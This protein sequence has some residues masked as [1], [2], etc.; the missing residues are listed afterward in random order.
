MVWG[1]VCLSFM[2]QL[3]DRNVLQAFTFFIWPQ[4]ARNGVFRCRCI[5]W[6]CS[7]NWIKKVIDMFVKSFSV[8]S[9]LKKRDS[10]V[11]SSELFWRE[12]SHFFVLK[13]LTIW[14]LVLRA[15]SGWTW[16]H[17]YINESRIYSRLS[18]SCYCFPDDRFVNIIGR[19]TWNLFFIVSY[20][21]WLRCSELLG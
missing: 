19:V 10:L 17:D 12:V 3:P 2:R 20:K 4:W 18:I 1:S 6:H 21:T 13:L 11:T 16:C 7:K 14:I 9:D 15:L 5:E 8:Q